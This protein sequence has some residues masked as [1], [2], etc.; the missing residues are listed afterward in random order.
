[1]DLPAHFC[2]AVI[3]KAATDAFCIELAGRGA[4]PLF[5]DAV[6]TLK[7]FGDGKSVLLQ[8][9]EKRLFGHYLASFMQRSGTCVGQGYTRA[10]QDAAFFALTHGGLIGRPVQLCFETIYAGARIN[11]GKGS[12]GSGD[13][14]CGVWAAQ[15]MH[16]YG[17]VERGVYGS[18]DLSK[19]REDLAVLW[20][21]PRHGVPQ[22]L[23][24]QSLSYKADAVMK[25]TSVEDVRDAL[26]AGYGVPRCANRATH[27]QRDANGMLAPSTSG[28]HCQEL[29]GV[30][31]DIKGDL[32][33]VEQQSWGAQGP[34]GGGTWKLQDGREI[35]PREGACGIRPEDIKTYLREGELW[36]LRPPL[37]MWADADVLPSTAA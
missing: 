16:D 9:A 17:L 30:F 19:P 34:V 27:G 18:I 1:M 15:F 28:G 6:P 24:D 5:C 20:G 25:C 29:C 33:F 2:S 36:A 8:E 4:E 32:I 13:G 37:T 21:A 31:I 22:V 7:G 26:A 14:A 12:L 23:L 3:D 11:V 35:M 10:M